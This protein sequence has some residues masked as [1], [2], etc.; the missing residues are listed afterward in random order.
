MLFP[1]FVHRIQIFVYLLQ[2]SIS[3]FHS[4]HSNTLGSVE[5]ALKGCCSHGT[6]G[7]QNRSFVPLLSRFV[8]NPIL[9]VSTDAR[10][11]TISQLSWT[12]AE[13]CNEIGVHIFC[14][15]AYPVNLDVNFFSDMNPTTGRTIKLNNFK[16]TSAHRV[17]L[18][19]VI[20]LQL[21]KNCD[22]TR[23]RHCIRSW[24]R[25]FQCLISIL[26]SHPHLGLHTV[27]PAQASGW[28]FGMQSSVLT[29]V[30]HF[31]AITAPLIWSSEGTSL[32]FIRSQLNPIH[33][34]NTALFQY[35]F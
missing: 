3:T 34:K 25:M 32:D 16:V 27:S 6:H 7:V 23:A 8:G 2:G 29:W 35:P 22:I 12:R 26:H 10:G 28:K 1:V 11:Q 15:Y 21:V 19:K 14:Y 5:L 33:L 4:C 18:Q 9:F 20:L 30:L 31:P 13:G 17:F 24:A